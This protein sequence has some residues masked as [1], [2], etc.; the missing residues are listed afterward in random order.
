L[1][2]IL[3]PL[4]FAANSISRL[5]PLQGELHTF[6]IRQVNASEAANEGAAATDGAV[7]AGKVADLPYA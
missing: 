1:S 2:E 5:R 4:R 7:G 3:I 6:F